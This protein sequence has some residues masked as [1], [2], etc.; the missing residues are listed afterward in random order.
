[1]VNIVKISKIRFVV[2]VG[3]LL[4][5][6]ALVIYRL[7][8]F[9][10]LQ[11]D[12]YIDI[13]YE[14]STSD[15]PISAR[16]GVIYDRN[17]VALANNTP[18]ERVFISP[19]EITD[20]TEALL[21]AQGLSEIL[22]VD[23][24]FVYDKTQKKL[25][26]DETIKKNVDIVTANIVRE[27]KQENGIKAIYF[28]Q[29][30]Q[31]V[32]PYSNLASHVIGFTGSDNNG[33]EGVEAQYD[34]YLKGVAGRIITARNAKGRAMDTEYE[35]YVD[36]QNG[37][38][39]VLTIDKSIQNFLENQLEAAY[40]ESKPN[41]KAYGI[42]MDVNTGEILALSVKP[43]YNLNDP[44]MLDEKS[45]RILD[46]SE[47]T[48]DTQKSEAELNLTYAMWRNSVI[49][50]PYEPGSTFKVITAS[51]AFEEK[52]VSE[53]TTDK[54]ECPGFYVVGGIKIKCHKVDGHGSVTFA[55]G[56]QASCNPT[57]MIAAGRLEG[58]PFLKYLEEFG[59]Y[60]RTGIDLPGEARSIMHQAANFRSV[61]LATSSFGQTFKVTPLQQIIGI[62]AVANGGK[63]VTPHVVKSII[64]E[65]RNII[66]SFGTEVKRTV[67]SEET[68]KTVSRIMAEGVA[69]G[70]AARNAFVK[71]YSIAAKTGTSE[72]RDNVDSEVRI[73]SCVA[74]APAENPQI[75]VLIIVDEPTIGS[76][77]GGVIAAP[78]V[79][80]FLADT[81]PYLGFD[82]KLS[83]EEKAAQPITVKNYINVDVE[84]A[85][86]HIHSSGL[87]YDIIGTGEFVVDQ[88]PKTGTLPK[89]GTI[90]LYTDKAISYAMVT[91]PDV[92]N[93][94]ADKA[95]QKIVNAGLN[96]R[97]I[98]E[99]DVNSTAIAY[100]QTPEAG[101]SVLPGSVVEVEF[102]YLDN[103]H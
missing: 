33:L 68:S 91:V 87:E 69:T 88:S 55:Q 38:S 99:N 100:K 64:D 92:K 21:I 95:N 58:Q 3:L 78:F 44:F 23:Y 14:Q 48:S 81:L 9:T 20:N 86:E 72:K 28:G 90:T 56:L 102:R 39:I 101:T 70:G 47:F 32:Y 43:D 83:E 8:D 42:A 54:F 62:A 37:Y 49:S 40:A 63:L 30:T 67:I 45:Q 89:G 66:K 11:H 93:L 36:A 6:V 51:M 35:T 82:P 22:G 4:L 18:V 79:S 1:M 31:R 50:D 85:K 84:S 34:E 5:L 13:A 75:A 80:K 65:E 57:L 52:K 46:A 71:G 16:R 61:E 94:T 2:T 74:F 24:H 73:G 15:T 53:S 12:K 77:Y 76:V 26:K 27:F 19:N 7:Y 41:N 10:I 59:Y 29:E 103:V 98:G 17:M 25:R 60:E 96:I 97:A